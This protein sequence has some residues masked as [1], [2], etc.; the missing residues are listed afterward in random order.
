MTAKDT[1]SP[2]TAHEQRK[3]RLAEELRANLL[4]RKAQA[5]SRRT[6]NPDDRPEGISAAGK[7]E[8]K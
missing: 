3:A 8:R 4:K 6:G 5:R 1:K 2:S 7:D